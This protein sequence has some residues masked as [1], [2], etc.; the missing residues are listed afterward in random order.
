MVFVD[1]SIE[2]YPVLL[3]GIKSDAK[4]F[5]L[6]DKE[7]GIKQISRILSQYKN[8]ESIHIVA[9][10][11]PGRLFLG[12]AELS[13]DTLKDYAEELQSFKSVPI[14]LY[15]CNVA[16]VD[17][18]AEFLEKLHQLTNSTIYASS[19]KVGNSARG[20]N[21]ILDVCQG[22][23]LDSLSLA[24]E[25]MVLETYAGVFATGTDENYTFFD[26]QEGTKGTVAFNDIKSSGTL[27]TIDGREGQTLVNLPFT[28]RYYDTDFTSITVGEN[29]GIIFGAATDAI[30]FNNGDIPRPNPQYS[31]FPFWDDLKGD[32]IYYKEEGDK[33]IIQWDNIAHHDVDSSDATFQIVLHKD[34]NNID[35]VYKDVDFG[36]AGYDFGK[37]AT[38]G[39]NKKDDV[40]L[41]YSFDEASLNGVTSIRFFTT[42]Q[43]DKV[44]IELKEGETVQLTSDNFRATDVD[45]ADNPGNIQ[46]V[47]SNPQNG[48]FRV[49]GTAATKFT[50]ADINAGKVEF[51]HDGG[52][53]PPSFEVQVTDG[54]NTSNAQIVDTTSGI[55]F[56]NVND[57]P[58]L[59]GLASEV[60]FDENSLNQ[61]AE[62][63]YSSAIV[64][65]IDSADFNGGS[66]TIEYTTDLKAADQLTVVSNGSITISD[67]DISYNGTVIGSIDGNNDG[68]DGKSLIIKLTS[69]DATPAAV[70]ALIENLNYQNTSD[71]PEASRTISIKL[72]DGD[73]GTSDAVETIIKVAAENDAPVNKVP[74]EVVQVSEDQT[75]T[76]GDRSISISDVDAGTNTVRVTLEATNGNLN[77][78]SANPAFSNLIFTTGDGTD[79]ATLE[80][81]GT[82]TDINTALDGMTFQP[83]ANYNGGATVNITTNDEGNSGAGANLTDSSTVNIDVIPINDAPVNTVPTT[84][85][86]IKEDT[87]LVFN[88]AN[89]NLIRIDDVDAEDSRGTKIVEVTLSVVKGTLTL[90]QETGLNFESGSNN[91]STMTI[92][93]QVGDINSAL[94]G[95]IYRG[96]LNANGDDTLSITTND[97]GNYGNGG[98]KTDADL[99]DIAI[100]A[101]NDAP[102]TT[103]PVAQN[104]AEDTNLIFS[105]ANSNSIA[106][107]DVDVVEGSEELEV[108]LSV[109]QGVLTL[110]DTTDIT[111]VSDTGNGTSNF[112]I[113][114]TLNAINRSLNGLIYRGNKDFNGSDTLTI[115]TSDLGHFGEGGV[116][117]DQKTV[118]ITVTPV[119]DVSINIVPGAQSINEDTDLV[120]SQAAGNNL[121][122]SDIDVSEGG[123]LLEVILTVKNGTLALGSTAELTSVSGNNSATVTI[124]GN[125]VNINN[126][127]EGLTYRG[128][129]NFNGYD[130]LTITT[131]DLGNTGS[132][133][134]LM[135]ED[136]VEIT[137][138][139]VNDAP[140]NTVP[141]VQT[142]NE[143]TDLALS[144]SNAISVSDIDAGEDQGE[145]EV[146]LSVSNGVLNLTKTDGISFDE[147]NGNGNST[148]TFKGKIPD[149]NIALNSLIYRGNLN[150]NGKE[151][152]TITTND[153]GNTGLNGALVDTDT[154]EI[155]VNA[156][157]DAPV[158]AVPNQQQI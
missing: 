85:Q 3:H 151:I 130:V 43:I 99:I 7:D 156:V 53:N 138:N 19:T 135:D 32:Q 55:T 75:L 131:N 152:L 92:R 73:G 126:G 101:V 153:L 118:D 86:T 45:N 139:A 36:N 68:S 65:D 40:G 25:E 158:N 89:N 15:G 120:F 44:E 77:L 123:D 10:G 142:V 20:G 115:N 98:N 8:V 14:A 28:F 95:L 104:I 18:G 56:T 121:G 112:V 154:V 31:M 13:L 33:F 93:G 1:S 87:D 81:T 61:A 23:K 22:E 141:D 119:N 62:I 129:E 79:D 6:I 41:K 150:F 114:G 63:V 147:N 83:E 46:F 66:L 157:N 70:K 17:A 136:T 26:S 50:Q 9:H 12:N 60:S 88:G 5:V 4:A 78:N 69:T 117:N 30:S 144:G 107:S 49:D 21:W 48:E 80:F 105:T 103:V 52:E 64:T 134:S 38:I 59:T 108:S 2:D 42:P 76:F 54:F 27:I 34:T 116:L 57:I 67:G 16:V 29:G 122:I 128:S 39:L 72:D 106:I 11:E 90:S 82:I 37:G 111:F 94:D 148:V 137:V 127:L 97:L 133:G 74:T 109:N 145:V 149:V 125:Q 58:E 96:N 47:I 143:D 51:V 71:T 110:A 100:S 102:V 35:F 91:S 146:T 113:K 155:N 140:V 84:T 124:T 132:G 24:F